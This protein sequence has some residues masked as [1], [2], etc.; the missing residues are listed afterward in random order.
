MYAK[1]RKCHVFVSGSYG[2]LIIFSFDCPILLYKVEDKYADFGLIKSL[3]S[4]LSLVFFRYSS[5]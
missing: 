2:K 1:Y 4:T 5:L 3:T